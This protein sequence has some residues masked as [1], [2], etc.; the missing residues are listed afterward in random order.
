MEK[1]A[2]RVAKPVDATPLAVFRFF[3]GIILFI[4][5][6]LHFKTYHIALLYTYE[7]TSYHFSYPY[8]SW[9]QPFS[10]PGT[11][12]EYAVMG[13]AALLLGLG[14]F[15]RLSA[16]T[17]FLTFTHLFLI[18][19]C[20]FQNHHYLIILISF[21]L[22]FLNAHHALSLDAY[23]HA[24]LR[25]GTVPFW[26]LFVLQAQIFIVYFFGGIAKINSDWL[27]GEPL[28][29]ILAGSK[30]ILSLSS[31][32]SYEFWVYAFSY[33]GLFFDLFIGFF[34]FIPRWRKLAFGATIAFNVINLILFPEITAFPFLMV[35][36]LFLFTDP[37][38]LR[39]ILDRKKFLKRFT[40]PSSKSEQ[41]QPVAA[42]FILAGVTV[43]LSI[44][45][46][47]PLRHFLYEGNASWTEEGHMFAWR[48]KLRDKLSYSAFFVTDLRTQASTKVDLLE[49]LNGLQS[50]TM[51][52]RPD[53]IYQFSQ[54]LKKKIEKSGAMKDPIIQAKIYCA[55][56][57][58][59]YQYLID[60][61]ADLT[62]VKY[63]PFS[64]SEWIM[65]LQPPQ[66]R[67]LLL[68][69]AI[70]IPPGLITALTNPKTVSISQSKSWMQGHE[71]VV[72]VYDGK[73]ARAY[74]IK[75]LS[76]HIVINDQVGDTPILVTY[77]LTRNLAK[78]YDRNIA[79]DPLTFEV[80][81]SLRSSDIILMDQTSH[82]YWTQL[83]GT[84]FSGK[85]ANRKLP[86]ITVEIL[87]LQHWE[88]K[89]PDSEVV[90]IPDRSIDYDRSPW[91]FYSRTLF[92]FR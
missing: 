55:L 72:G 67:P 73:V 65:P 59:Y 24:K 69:S 82:S 32:T 80:A 19:Q 71:T 31:F 58:R 7:H 39:T 63:S 61:E 26:N 45:S 85:L 23:R 44:Q 9:I 79:N 42:K 56:N 18:D 4:E 2:A 89:H 64:H 33:G 92:L 37:P 8:L 68:R 46:L 1:L 51:S 16:L 28:R 5:T 75:I 52:M 83:N 3:F 60:P 21:L 50:S 27:H 30:F 15:Y 78:A 13:V 90:S 6:L 34:F 88:T 57:G 48:M 70:P 35:A 29:Q 20:N 62:K 12:I 47:V 38:Y 53:L 25:K 84:A 74:P 91:D 14:L 76:R 77:N 87:P 54:F 22:I 36:A 11:Y 41:T 86:E 66:D 49:H 81:G 40:W 17:F 10:T 43:Y